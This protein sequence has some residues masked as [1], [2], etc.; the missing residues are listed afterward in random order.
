MKKLMSSRVSTFF[1]VLIQKVVDKTVFEDAKWEALFDEL[2]S[3]KK[4]GATRVEAQ[5]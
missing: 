5:R 3:Y 4:Y 1:C 2:A